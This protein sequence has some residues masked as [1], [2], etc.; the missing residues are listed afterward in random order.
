MFLLE[1]NGYVGLGLAA[2]G[3]LVG[4]GR[5]LGLF[6]RRDLAG[7]RLVAFGLEVGVIG[8]QMVN[9]EQAR[10]DRAKAAHGR[11]ERPEGLCNG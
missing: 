1:V 9:V 11:Q 7:A 6:L 5:G 3:D 10:A 8:L 2:V 4:L